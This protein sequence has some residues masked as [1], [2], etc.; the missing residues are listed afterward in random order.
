MTIP[1]FQFFLKEIKI[2]SSCCYNKD[3]FKTVIELMAQGIGRLLPLLKK[4]LTS[5][6]KFDGYEKMVTTRIAL[7]DVVSKGFEELVNNR[8]E[9]IKIL[10]SPK[11]VS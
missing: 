11:A 1:F 8:D 10:I 2:V 9:H 4:T 5:A 6:G 3:D 7:E